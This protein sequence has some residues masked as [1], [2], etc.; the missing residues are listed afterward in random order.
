MLVASV[1]GSISNIAGPP[2]IAH[3][4]TIRG[5]NYYLLCMGIRLNARAQPLL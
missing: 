4:Q 5:L 2:C 1:S 3:G